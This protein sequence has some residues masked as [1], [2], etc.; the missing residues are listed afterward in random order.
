[1]TLQPG[2]P[3][4]RRVNIERLMQGLHD[5]LYRIQMQPTGCRWWYGKAAEIVGEDERVPLDMVRSLKPPL[6]LESLDEVE[7]RISEGKMDVGF[8]PSQP[9]SFRW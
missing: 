2:I 4:T 5:R 7:L 6:M 8:L 3:V 1:M 9:Q